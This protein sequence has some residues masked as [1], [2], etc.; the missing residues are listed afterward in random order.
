MLGQTLQP[1]NQSPLHHPLRE[2]Q[3]PDA[4]NQKWEMSLWIAQQYQPGQGI[5]APVLV[6]TCGLQGGVGWDLGTTVA[7]GAV[8][9]EGLTDGSVRLLGEVG[10]VGAVTGTAMA[11]GTPSG[12]RFILSKSGQGIVE[13]VLGLITSLH[14]G[15]ASSLDSIFTMLQATNTAVASSK[16]KYL[17]MRCKCWCKFN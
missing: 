12:G 10:G 4:Q 15:F 2:W 3:W 1:D 5:T 17:D 14:W 6:L 11:D 7:A 9:L 13:P 16:P 8:R